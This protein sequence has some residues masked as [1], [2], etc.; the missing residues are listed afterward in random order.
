MS[1]KKFLLEFRCRY[2]IS[3]P[4]IN[5]VTMLA[6]QSMY[7]QYCWVDFNKGCWEMAEVA[8]QLGGMVKQIKAYSTRPNWPTC[9]PT[10]YVNIK[11][12]GNH[13]ACSKPPVYIES[14]VLVR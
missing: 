6:D 9:R 12:Q 2:L 5:L 13:S 8:K 7:R 3:K 14:Y 4:L 10:L 11:V 1:C